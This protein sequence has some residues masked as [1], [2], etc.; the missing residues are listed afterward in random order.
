[1]LYYENEELVSRDLM[2]IINEPTSLTFIVESSSAA[3]K[4][5]YKLA[6]IFLFASSLT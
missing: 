6:F 2:I 4:I 1:M 5:Y 3:S